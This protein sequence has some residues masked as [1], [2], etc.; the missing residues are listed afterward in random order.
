MTALLALLVTALHAWS[1]HPSLSEPM[2]ASTV[3]AEQPQIP[4]RKLAATD[5][6]MELGPELTAASAAVI[7]VA[8]GAVLWGKQPYLVRPLASVTK[9]LTAIAYEDTGPTLITIL[10]EDIP[11]EGHTVLR[12][13]DQV[14]T[15]DALAAMLVYSD[16]AAARA[17]AR[18][19][20]AHATDDVLAAA[21]RRLGLRSFRIADPAGLESANRGTAIDAARLL[22]AAAARPV[23]RE[24]LGTARVT[25]DA[26]RPDRRAI[27]V[28]TT[29]VL[30]T[31][32][33]AHPYELL[34]GKTGYL[35]EAGYN[36]V[37]IVARDGHA[38]AVAILGATTHPDRFRDA[39]VLAD[40][41]FD[42]FSW[43]GS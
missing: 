11:R 8:S 10:A 16:N 4:V 35:D 22:I 28:T 12:P 37:A 9:V 27:A 7:D 30:L 42:A 21:A 36:F 40:W 24:L 29:N 43:N 20:D 25:I 41:I 33:R 13:G 2:Q 18:T 31:D 32:N 5:E 19:D 39:G 3:V 26:H 6:A 23:L 34:G 17:L 15:R 14:T 38:I 1:A